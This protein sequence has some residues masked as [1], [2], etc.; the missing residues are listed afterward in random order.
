MPAALLALVY[1]YGR[2]RQPFALGLGGLA[3]GIAYAHILAD[4]PEWT[5]Y[6]VVVLSVLAAI[7]DWR[8]VG[9]IP[10]RLSAERF[11]AQVRRL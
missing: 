3:V 10:S 4:T 11:H 2:H 9:S 8:A 7:T 6:L 5:L 1:G